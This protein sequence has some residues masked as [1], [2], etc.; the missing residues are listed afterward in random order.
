MNLADHIQNSLTISVVIDPE[1]GVEVD[2]CLRQSDLDGPC[3]VNCTV[4]RVAMV[5]TVRGCAD[6]YERIRSVGVMATFQITRDQDL[7][8]K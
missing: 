6:R 7:C 8:V 2:D 1:S 4:R 3:F 5:G